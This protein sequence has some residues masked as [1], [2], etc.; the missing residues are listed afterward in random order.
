MKSSRLTVKSV[1]FTVYLMNQIIEIQLVGEILDGRFWWI[2]R[3]FWRI[4]SGIGVGFGNCGGL[5]G[6]DGGVGSGGLEDRRL[7]MGEGGGGVLSG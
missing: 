6:W 2:L 1:D 7:R 4:C 5:I 3:C